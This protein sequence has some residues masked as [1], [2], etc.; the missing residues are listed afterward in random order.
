M[1]K[2]SRLRG[3]LEL[4]HGKRAEALIQSQR[5][6][7]YH[8]NWSLWRL[9]GW[10]NLLLVTWKILRLFVHTLTAD[11]NYSLLRSDNLIQRIHMHLSEK[12]KTFSKISSAFFKS[13]LNFELFQENMTLIAYVFP[14]LLTPKDSFR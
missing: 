14:N 7:L 1:S 4:A 8:I 2:K 3:H 12:Q 9:L 13:T 10:K 5:Q 6:D 11:Y